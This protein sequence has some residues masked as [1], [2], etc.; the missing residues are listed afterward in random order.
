M[1]KAQKIIAKSLNYVEDH[2][3]DKISLEEIARNVGVS[4]YHLHRLFKSLT[5]ETII[6][7][8]TCRKLASSVNE[9]LKTD[10]RVIDIAHEYG[11]EYEQSYIRAFQKEFRSTPL[12]IRNSGQSVPLK[13]PLNLNEILSVEDAII[14]RPFFV[15]K[16]AF[17]LAGIRHEIPL[18]SDYQIPN[19]VGR[20]F[21]YQHKPRIKNI[22]NPDV[23]FG[24]VNWG[25]EQSSGYT[26]YVPSVQVKDKRDI[27]E[28][29]TVISIPTH[30]YVVFRFVGFFH[31]DQVNVRHFAHLLE[32]MYTKWIT[33]AGYE[34][35][36]SFHLEYIDSRLAK[37]DYCELDLYQPIKSVTSAHV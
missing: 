11:F 1:N 22:V 13:E 20:E 36:D 28:E 6:N 24:Y 25:R 35:A 9:L 19:R 32:Y 16:P 18:G 2:L 34:I 5:G 30:K 31:A 12:K 8:A 33:K 17:K 29:M 27:P 23:Y 7:Y 3:K 14:Y 21:F 37:D 15:I 26:I 10:L 4:K